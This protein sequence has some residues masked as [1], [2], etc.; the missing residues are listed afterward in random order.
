MKLVSTYLSELVF[1]SQRDVDASR[2]LIWD[3]QNPSLPLKTFQNPCY[4]VTTCL[5]DGT[6]LRPWL[7]KELGWIGTTKIPP[8]L[9]KPFRIRAIQWLRVWP[10]VRN[11]GHDWGRNSVDLGRQKSFSR[12]EK[13]ARLHGVLCSS[14]PI[15]L[16]FDNS[17]LFL[18][19]AVAWK[20]GKNESF[21][22]WN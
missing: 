14:P 1:K 18:P 2:G 4:S 5:T 15:S 10:M 7:R 11:W 9:W 13:V 20:T 22:T 19:I 3:D 17:Y 21:W 12:R 8:C 16:F 6:K